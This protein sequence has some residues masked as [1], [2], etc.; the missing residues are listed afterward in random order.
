MTTTIHTTGLTL[1]LGNVR[2]LLAEADECLQPFSKEARQLD[3]V[4]KILDSID[5]TARSVVR[6]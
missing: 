2:S 6:P 3:E 4:V 5:T 1:C